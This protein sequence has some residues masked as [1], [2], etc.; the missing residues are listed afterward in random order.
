MLDDIAAQVIARRVGVPPGA[1]QQVLQPARTL[2]P[3]MLGDR[4]T[5]RPAQPGE[6]PGHQVPGMP[7]R[8]HTGEPRREPRHQRLELR[9]PT[10][11]V[12]DQPSSHCWRALSL[13]K[14]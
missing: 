11:T 10:I 14:P 9:L 5:V 7:T 2:V 8:L 6:H 12:Y 4:P 13:H 3:D 1:R